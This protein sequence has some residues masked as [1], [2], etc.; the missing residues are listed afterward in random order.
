MAKL[1]YDAQQRM[2]D[3]ISLAA[4]GKNQTEIAKALGYADYKPLWAYARRQGYVWDNTL[5]NYVKRTEEQEEEKLVKAIYPKGRVGRIMEMFDQGMDAREIAR[6]QRFRGPLEMADF[7]RDNGYIWDTEGGNYVYTPFEKQE[8]EQSSASL[9]Q[10][11]MSEFFGKY[12]SVLN[13]LAENRDKLESMLAT[14]TAQE[15]TLPRYV[16]PGVLVTKSL[17]MPNS[18]DMLMKEFSARKN[19]AQKDIM[20]IAL[21]EFFLRHGFQDEIRRILKV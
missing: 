4:E 9:A 13:F 5:G 8:E 2:K 10:G 21:V 15:G 3:I 18:L 17:H 12:S 19:M 11:F 14:G 1:R 16:I 6:Q 20:V 7:M